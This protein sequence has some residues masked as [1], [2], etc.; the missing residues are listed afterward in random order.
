[1]S[2]EQWKKVSD[3]F[4][5][6]VRRTPAERQSFL[7][8]ACAGDPA[9]WAEVERLIQAHQQAGDFL[10]QPI[11]ERPTPTIF[12]DNPAR[13]NAR[14]APDFGAYHVLGVLGEGGMGIVYLAEA[15]E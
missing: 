8:Q 6:V 11:L 10:E 14:M 9:V 13:P 12:T 1:M 2:P 7:D 3:I 15:R 5:D 4:A